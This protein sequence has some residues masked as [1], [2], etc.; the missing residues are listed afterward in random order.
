MPKINETIKELVNQQVL[1]SNNST[2]FLLKDVKMWDDGT[3]TIEIKHTP[4]MPRNSSKEKIINF[5]KSL[6]KDI[7]VEITKEDIENNTTVLDFTSYGKSSTF[8]NTPLTF[9]TIFTKEEKEVINSHNLLVRKM[10]SKNEAKKFINKK[11]KIGDILVLRGKIKDGSEKNVKEF[12]V[13]KVIWSVKSQPVNVLILKQLSG[14][15][16]NMSL[17]RNDCKKY[18]IK[19]EPGLQVYSMSLN[20][21]KKKRYEK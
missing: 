6:E 19:Y 16:T 8:Y 11:Y 13:K 20:F 12:E 9:E 2:Y 4:L 7:L 14:M 15:N 3:G 17:N 1:N 18:H 10:I 5:I 21:N